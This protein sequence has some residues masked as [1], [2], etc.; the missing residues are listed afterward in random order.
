MEAKENYLD[1][2]YLK[3]LAPGPGEYF[4]ITDTRIT[5]QQYGPENLLMWQNKSI[6]S[7]FIQSLTRISQLKSAVSRKSG[8]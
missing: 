2:F 7:H 4:F 3:P 5:Q 8:L 1:D 6:K